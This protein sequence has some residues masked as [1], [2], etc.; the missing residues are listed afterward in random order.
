MTAFPV[1]NP[2]PMYSRGMVTGKFHGV[3]AAHVPTGRWNVNIRLLRSDVGITS[4]DSRF[5]SSA[6]LRK[7]SL[8]SVMSSSDS[9]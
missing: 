7:Y 4:P 9:L 6:A 3:M 2:G 8:A 1:A 5:T